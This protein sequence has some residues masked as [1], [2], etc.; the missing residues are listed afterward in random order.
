MTVSEWQKIE[1][2]A[3]SWLQM[4]HNDDDTYSAGG[5]TDGELNF[6]LKILI[7]PVSHTAPLPVTRKYCKT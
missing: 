6:P 1:N 4:A 7:S 3:D 2:D 5:V